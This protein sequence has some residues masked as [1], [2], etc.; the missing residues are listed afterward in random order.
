[1]KEGDATNVDVTSFSPNIIVRRIA[2]IGSD[3]KSSVVGDKEE[4]N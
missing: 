4:A 2:V 1:L 3:D